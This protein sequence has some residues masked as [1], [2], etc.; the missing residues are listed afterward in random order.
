[1]HAALHASMQTQLYLNERENLKPWL[2]SCII[3]SLKKTFTKTAV[4]SIQHPDVDVARK[5][6]PLHFSSNSFTE[7]PN[8]LQRMQICSLRWQRLA[9]LQNKYHVIRTGTE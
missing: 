6:T 8:N 4:T 1:M 2:Q 3:T 7:L 5:Q 9:G